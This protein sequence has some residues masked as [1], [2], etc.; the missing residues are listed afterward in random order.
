MF[1]AAPGPGRDSGPAGTAQPGTARGSFFRALGDWSGHGTTAFEAL[2]VQGVCSGGRGAV[3]R[4]AGEGRVS[5]TGRRCRTSPP[6]CGAADDDGGL[7]LGS[8]AASSTLLF[9]KLK[10]QKFWTIRKK[11][12]GKK[13]VKQGRRPGHQL[14]VGVAACWCCGQ[15]VAR[16]RDQG[17][18][19]YTL[20]GRDRRAV[21]RA[22]G[23]SA[24][25]GPSRAGLLCNCKICTITS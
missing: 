8:G 9:G 23:L 5:Q 14:R 15:P 6:C 10:L 16:G 1:L 12:Q 7:G 11:N 21:I 24:A 2:A 22:A 4:V 3:P 18:Y 20:L 17:G 19:T 25:A 13:R